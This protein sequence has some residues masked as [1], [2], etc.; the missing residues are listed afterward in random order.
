MEQPT[1]TYELKQ[2]VV[3]YLL[4]AC[5][6]QQIRGVEQA[7]DLIAVVNLLKKPTNEADLEKA[8]LETLKAKYD[9]K[10]K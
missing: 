4:N 6:A 10:A 2:E 5:N 3:N 9:K 1:L 7:N 8:T